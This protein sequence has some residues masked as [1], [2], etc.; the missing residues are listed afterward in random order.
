MVLARS[1]NTN[2]SAC[3]PRAERVG[4]QLAVHVGRLLVPDRHRRRDHVRQL[5]AL[6]YKAYL[7]RAAWPAAP[8]PTRS[9]NAPPGTA[10]R[11]VAPRFSD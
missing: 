1:P 9:A 2:A 6:G 5:E 3:A 11:P 8:E 7:E 10:A 4:H